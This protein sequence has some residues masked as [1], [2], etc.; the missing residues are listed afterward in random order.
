MKKILIIVLLIVRL[1]NVH[2]QINNDS[3]EYRHI[4]LIETSSIFPG[5][6]DSLMCFI[7]SNLD[8]EIL[9]FHK[10]Y[11]RVRAFFVIDTLGKVTDIETN[12]EHA[13]RFGWDLKDSLIENEIKRVLK[14]LPDWTPAQLNNKPV[15]VGYTLPIE[16]PYTNFKCRTIDNPTATYWNVDKNAIFQYKDEIDTKES[17]IKFTKEHLIAPSEDDCSGKV[18][19][20]TLIDESGKLTDLKVLG[21]SIDCTGFIEEALRIVEL[22]PNWIPAEINGKYVK[23][24]NVIPIMF[25]Y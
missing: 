12:S 16:I 20:R 7:E 17:I 4:D 15:R 1:L 21:R 22:M 14:L 25:L 13:Q 11:G 6:E 2:S 10:D 3:I 19:I 8:F 24:Y 18:F 23:S 9:N 5:G